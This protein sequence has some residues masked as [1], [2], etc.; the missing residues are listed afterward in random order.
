MP[1]YF[2]NMIHQVEV[3]EES[4]EESRENLGP[5]ILVAEIIKIQAPITCKAITRPS[6][7]QR[8][9]PPPTRGFIPY[10]QKH[11]SYSFNLSKAESIFDELLRNKVI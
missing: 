10:K 3:V 1:A 5:E 2:K 7:E 8:N 4:D 9:N 6:K 11:K